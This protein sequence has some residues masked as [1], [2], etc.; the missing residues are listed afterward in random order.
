MKTKIASYIEKTA[1]S[2][3]MI[4]SI[5]LMSACQSLGPISADTKREF[6]FDYQVPGKS[7]DEL[8]ASAL[9]FIAMSYGDSN[10]VL[11]IT[12]KDGG[13]IAGKGMSVWSE[14]GTNRHTPHEIKFMAKDGKARL[15]L[16]IPGT[17]QP[18]A[19]GGVYIWPLPTP[20]GY[21]Q[22]VQ[23]FNDFSIALEKELQG[24]SKSSSFSDF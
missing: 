15:Q 23:Q 20:G 10:S 3:M 8:Y 22:V 16:S 9:T 19:I 2:L 18:S 1:K 12:D 11:K 6:V 13:L 7:K 24:S 5:V 17:A 21:N 14:I 4:T